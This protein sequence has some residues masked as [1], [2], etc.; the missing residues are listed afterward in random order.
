MTIVGMLADFIAADGGRSTAPRSYSAFFQHVAKHAVKSMKLRALATAR[1]EVA[2]RLT[3]TK[4]WL[5]LS[6]KHHRLYYYCKLCPNA[7]DTTNIH[8]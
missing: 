6:L 1:P 5:F 7:A 2:I 3:M 8:Y 4:T